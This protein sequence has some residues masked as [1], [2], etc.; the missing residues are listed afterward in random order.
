MQNKVYG[1]LGPLT[2]LFPGYPQD[3]VDVCKL[4]VKCPTKAKGSY[5]EMVGLPVAPSDP[6]VS[7]QPCVRVCVVYMLI[8]LPHSP[9]GISDCQVGDHVW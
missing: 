3:Q 7:T 2:V 1:E 8:F 6:K 4:G 9:V 5:T